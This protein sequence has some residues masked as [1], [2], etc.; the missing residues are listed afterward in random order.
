MVQELES[1][2]VGRDSRFYRQALYEH[3]YRITDTVLGADRTRFSAE[4][5]GQEI[6]L[7]VKLD[8]HTGKSTN[9]EALIKGEPSRQSSQMS[10]SQ[11]E[12][13]SGQ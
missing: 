9:V 2:P 5:N 1:L 10:Q 12:F 7:N 4:K 8:E 3:G 13:A 6:I 11:Y